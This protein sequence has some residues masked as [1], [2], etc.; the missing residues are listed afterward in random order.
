MP[1]SRSASKPS[2]NK[3]KSISPAGMIEPARR[4]ERADE[5]VSCGT[6]S[7]STSKRPIKVLFPSSTLPQVRSRIIGRACIRNSPPS[8]S[9]PSNL[10]YRHQSIGLL[11]H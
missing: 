5:T 11:V 6:E 8:F 9:F 10:L 1:C 4:T 7:V 2:V 3:L